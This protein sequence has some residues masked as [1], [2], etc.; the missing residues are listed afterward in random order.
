MNKKISINKIESDAYNLF[1]D[2]KFYCSEAIVYV[3]RE[4]ID[5]Q[6]PSAVIRTASGFPD[7]IGKSKCVC[8][9]VSGAV[10]AL[11]YFFGRDLPG[12]ADDASSVQT[13]EL[14]NELQQHFRDRYKNVL[15]C[16]VHLQGITMGSVE[17]KTQCATFTAAMAK[18]TAE[19]IA[20]ELKL[21]VCDVIE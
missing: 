14:A 17:H 1:M 7:G 12:A 11:G 3:L 4:N 9:A 5:P 8:G 16:H 10:I 19:I 6:M 13:I 20:R 15:C 21:E 2:G 18:K